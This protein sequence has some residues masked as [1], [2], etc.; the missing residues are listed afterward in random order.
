MNTISEKLESA[1]IDLPFGGLHHDIP[2]DEGHVQTLMT[3]LGQLGQLSPILVRFETNEIID[4]FHRVEALRRL[5]CTDARC[6]LIS[7]SDEEF[8]DARITSAVLHK[9][10]EFSRVALWTQEIFAA[11]PWGDRLKASDAFKLATATP[12]K[13]VYRKIVAENNLS[14]NEAREIVDW[15][16]QKGEVWGIGLS[17]IHYYLTIAER[18]TP[19]IVSLVRDG[20]E[21]KRGQISQSGVLTRQV[22]AAIAKHIPDHTDQRDVAGKIAREGLDNRSA[23]NLIVD[24][25]SRRDPVE[26]EAILDAP[27][28]SE[29]QE[30]AWSTEEPE[31][32]AEID[33]VAEERA[34][35]ESAI[36]VIQEG[37]R[38]LRR[39]P[40]AGKYPDLDGK[41][42]VA[43]DDFIAQASQYRD[44]S[45]DL[46]VKLRRETAQLRNEN[47]D[48]LRR[49]EDLQYVAGI[50]RR[51]HEH[52]LRGAEE[53]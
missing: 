17:Q 48:L 4:G 1:E 30:E 49:L 8:R 9:G 47:T 38:L 15:A 2:V 45:S 25:S 37:A 39:V 46:L 20:A 40:A 33:W 11:T 26:R 29:G 36:Q 32:P 19:E 24:F 31:T 52:D 5:G 34:R 7:C 28:G 21:T 42:G 14:K 41:L 6:R 23:R 51:I 3:S 22:V 50:A 13:N 44:T 18:T 27:W 16:R 43:I 35:M 53:S 12:Y 10:V